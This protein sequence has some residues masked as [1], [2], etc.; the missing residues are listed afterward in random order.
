MFKYSFYYLVYSSAYFYCIVIRADKLAEAF[1]VSGGIWLI[2]SNYFH[3]STFL[4][5]NT[6]MVAIA[7]DW[8]L[9]IDEKLKTDN[10]FKL[11]C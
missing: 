10:R 6:Y 8:Q 3:H 9:W 4:I 2:L 5:Q 1:K 11:P 7:M